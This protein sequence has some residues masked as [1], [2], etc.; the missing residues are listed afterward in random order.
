MVGDSFFSKPVEDYPVE[1]SFALTKS[2][3]YQN[4]GSHHLNLKNKSI[5]GRK[6]NIG[7]FEVDVVWLY[8]L[9][10]LIIVGVVVGGIICCCSG[11]EDDK[12]QKEKD[13]NKDKENKD[14]S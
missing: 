2:F 13:A 3:I 14:K 4:D 5:Y 8:I 7:A 10:V 11:S 6:V 12:A 9:G 1:N